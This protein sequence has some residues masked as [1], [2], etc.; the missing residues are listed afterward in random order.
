MQMACLGQPPITSTAFSHRSIFPALA[1][2]FRTPSQLPNIKHN[3]Y[4]RRAPPRTIVAA[5]NGWR[6]KDR[7]EEEAV[8]QDERRGLLQSVLWGTEA[9]YIIW[10][11]LLPYAPGDPVWA[12]SPSTLDDLLSLSLNFFFV[13][14][15]LNNR[16]V[17]G[18]HGVEA[19][20][21]HPASEGLF[22]FV[23]GWTFMFAPLL[24]T[25]YRRNRYK[26]SLDILWGM[27]MFLT[28]VFLIPYMAIRLN[29]KDSSS[30]GSKS[31]SAL[32]S[33]MVRGKD[34]VGVVGGLVCLG[35]LLWGV[36][37]RGDSGFGGV[38]DR[39]EFV[40][41]YIG[42]ERLAYAFV[43]DI[44]LYSIFQPWLIGAN[45][46]NLNKNKV[47]LVNTLRFLPVVGLVTYLLCLDLDS[48]TSR[49]T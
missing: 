16:T 6:K 21:I 29:K 24:F 5:R 1:S 47:G 4:H 12:I 3:I 40:E 36:Y 9:V 49:P 31:S 26:S 18:I 39:W 35:S 42:S 43:I 45:L 17:V 13:L 19:P 38:M 11:F 2:T 32:G 48:T 41:S 7:S 30:P 20:L 10:L 22:N 33:L 46:E 23:I 44:G 14:P 25:D 27:Q 15:I 37:G 34:V 8:L 28:N